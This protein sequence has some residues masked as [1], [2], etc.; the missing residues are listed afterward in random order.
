MRYLPTLPQDDYEVLEGVSTTRI[1]VVKKIKE[2]K[3]RRPKY[4]TVRN[5]R[6]AIP[7]NDNVVVDGH[8]V[9]A[10]MYHPT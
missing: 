9:D 2:M 3:Y 4:N 10:L 7:T 6:Q 5:N 1:V 8:V